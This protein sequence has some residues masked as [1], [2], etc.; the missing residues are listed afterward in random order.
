DALVNA[1]LPW[2][3]SVAHTRREAGI[4][5]LVLLNDFEA[6]ACAM[7][8]IDPAAMTR[9]CGPD[10]IGAGP[11]LVLGPGTGLGAAVRLPGPPP[12]VLASE[13]G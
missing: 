9:V 8:F 7:P 4:G 13:A 12:Q 11:A 10:R 3:M 6:V 5:Q 1:N 2:P